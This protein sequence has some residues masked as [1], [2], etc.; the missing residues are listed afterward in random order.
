MIVAEGIIPKLFYEASII[1][2]PKAEKEMTRSTDK[3]LMK[4]DAKFST[5]VSLNKH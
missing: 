4:I 1:L 5:L 2:M 3:S